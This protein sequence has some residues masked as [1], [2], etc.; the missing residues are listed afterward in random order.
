MASSPAAEAIS[1]FA[2]LPNVEAIASYIE[3]TKQTE[4]FL[5]ATPEDK[6]EIEKWVAFARKELGDTSGGFEKAKHFGKLGKLHKH[7]VPRVFLV[8]N[9]LTAADVAVYAALV[10]L[11]PGLDS[12]T[13]FSF[14]G[15]ARWFDFIQHHP[16]VRSAG[17]PIVE[18]DLNYP[19]NPK[20]PKKEEKPAAQPKPTEQA[21]EKKAEAS[22]EAKGKAP[23]QPKQPKAQPAAAA[24]AGPAVPDI[25]RLDIRV[26]QI[27]S[28]KKH[29]S[30]DSLYLE[31]IDLGEE[32][33]RQ[34]VSGLVNFIPIEQMQDARVICLCNLKPAKMRGIESQAMVL[35]ASNADHTAVELIKPPAEAKIGERIYFEGYEGEPDKELNPKKKI[36]EGLK[37]DLFINPDLVASYRDSEKKR[38]LAFL[39]SAGPCK[40]SSHAGGS[41]S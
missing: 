17:V 15:A 19:L 22:A 41:I 14:A 29:P 24:A 39:T 6:K 23:R 31:E 21:A 2:A 38:E 36:F 35:C 28:V 12:H 26:G 1:G 37:P 25:V 10:P 5:G 16:A 33:V 8:S 40:A 27:K 3:T 18:L 11:V 34:V 32:K 9:N 7:L 20:P 4:S 30:A 13:Q